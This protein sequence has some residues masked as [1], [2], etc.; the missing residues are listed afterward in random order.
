MKIL[1]RGSKKQKILSLAER[2]G[3]NIDADNPDVVISYG[4]D[5][6]IMKAV[7]AHPDVPILAL[8]GSRICKKCVAISTD[9]ALENL[10]NKNYKVENSLKLEANCG[11]KTLYAMDSVVV[12]NA[13]PRHAIRYRVFLN[14]R[15]LGHEVIGDGVVIATPFGATGYYRSITDSYFEVGIGLA[16]NNSTEQADHIVL[17][18][19]TEIKIQIVRGPAEVY[20]D[21]QKE[22]IQMDDGEEV[23][24]K[25]SKKIA[26][27]IKM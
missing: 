18:S 19:D 20:A 14:G 26:K 8:R 5:G 17:A 11:G 13:D 2:A 4:G 27:L 12:H 23:V 9:K 1:I 6:A 21:N 16:F 25:K 22:F 7:F 10:R 15:D 3:L 24:I